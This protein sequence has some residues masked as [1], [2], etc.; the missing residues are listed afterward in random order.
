ML[1]VPPK[2]G[3]ADGKVLKA[4]SFFDEMEIYPGMSSCPA[5][6]MASPILIFT[7]IQAQALQED[8]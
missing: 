1:L 6:H 2:R 5:A 8:P 4:E 7:R 3:D